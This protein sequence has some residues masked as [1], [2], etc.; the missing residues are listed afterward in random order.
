MNEK[1]VLSIITANFDLNLWPF[2][3]AGDDSPCQ[4]IFLSFRLTT[5]RRNKS[6]QRYALKYKKSFHDLGIQQLSAHILHPW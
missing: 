3:L 4:G 1:N 6:K 2:G 5:S